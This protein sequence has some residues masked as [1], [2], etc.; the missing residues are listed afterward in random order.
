MIHIV[1]VVLIVA[2]VV[3]LTLM[4]FLPGSYDGLAA[5][6]SA[7]AQIFGKVG[8]L[9]VPVGAVWLAA[10]C[11][12]RLARRRAF[13]RAALM[14]SSIVWAAI[15]LGGFVFSGRVLGIGALVFWAYV[16]WRVWPRLQ[17]LTHVTPARRSALPLYL[18]AVPVA[19]LLAQA[20]SAGPAIDF[21][22]A[23]AIRNSAPLIA[24]IERYRATNGH[25]PV[26]LLSLLEDYHPDVVGIPRYLYE[27]SGAAFNLGF[28]QF[29]F[30]LAARE[31]VLYNPRDEQSISSHNQ[32]L[33]RLAP[34]DIAR[35][36]GFFAA[37]EA[38]QPHWKYFR[39]D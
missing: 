18:V 5:P 12:G 4:P 16:L 19:V 31:I 13:A 39:F 33:L 8:L 26:S 32:D 27:P 36:R 22:R 1:G 17:V 14:A 15:A 37:H 6:V 35:Q 9:L 23:R 3:V 24:D 10:E 21:S 29:T 30:D 34:A 38:P 11:R 25:Y 28:E 7:M 2:G 20:A